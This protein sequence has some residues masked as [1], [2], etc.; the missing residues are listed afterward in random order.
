MINNIH[1]SKYCSISSSDVEILIKKKVI[2]SAFETSEN[3]KN[4]LLIKNLT[5]FGFDFSNIDFSKFES[6]ITYLEKILLSFQYLNKKELNYQL[7][8]EFLNLNL[9]KQVYNEKSQL[10]LHDFEVVSLVTGH[11]F[12]INNECIIFEFES[13]IIDYDLNIYLCVSKLNELNYKYNAGFVIDKHKVIFPIINEYKI[14][15]PLISKQE[16]SIQILKQDLIDILLF[17]K[18]SIINLFPSIYKVSNYKYN[19]FIVGSEFEVESIVFKKLKIVM[20]N[21]FDNNV[22]ILYEVSNDNIT[23]NVK[24]NYDILKMKMSMYI[25]SNQKNY[26]YEFLKKVNSLNKFNNVEIQNPFANLLQIISEIK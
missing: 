6:Y 7:K 26:K 21:N 19:L 14:D 4:V 10:N 20:F 23:Y 25:Y 13:D 3:I 5:K 1:I 9:S 11:D 22:D 15:L 2:S 24:I 16:K 18:K 12:T 17:E 8:N